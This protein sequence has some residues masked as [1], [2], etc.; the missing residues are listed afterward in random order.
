MLPNKPT[1]GTQLNRGHP[2]TRGLVCALPLNEPGNQ[3]HNLVCGD[4]FTGTH[5]PGG[6]ATTI[7]ASHADWMNLQTRYTFCIWHGGI[8]FGNWD[9]ILY[10]HDG[11]SGYKWQRYSSNNCIR[12]YHSGGNATMW[13]LL[14]SEVSEPGM[15]AARW[16][17][18]ECVAFVDGQQA[19][20]VAMSWTPGTSAANLTFGLAAY[21]AHLILIY[22]RALPLHEIRALY[23]DPTSVFAPAA[24]GATI[25]LSDGVTHNLAGSITATSGISG[26]AKTTRAVCGSVHAVTSLTALPNRM[27]GLS[28]ASVATTGLLASLSSSGSVTLSGM[29]NAA[30]SLTASLQI[31]SPAPTPL[32]WQKEALFNGMTPAAFRLGTVLTQGWF[33]MRRSGCSAVYRGPTIDQVDDTSPVAVANIDAET[34]PLPAYLAHDPGSRC[35]YVVQRFNGCG[36]RERTLTAAVVVRTGLDGQLAEPV[37]NDVFELKATTFAGNRLHLSWFYCPL[38]QA[39][40]PRQFSVYWDSGTGQVDLDTPLAE[41]P[42]EGRRFYTYKTNPLDDGTYTFLVSANSTQQTQSLPGPTVCCSIRQRI[43]EAVRVL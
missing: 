2:L 16:N 28:A 31:A 10:C 29:L 22:D 26:T 18:V 35:C 38:D 32:P 7:S 6:L 4:I 17:G 42:Y 36:Y 39:V 14:T 25:A 15:F 1:P 33:W 27:R 9:A 19:G 8:T 37:P 11:T 12:I 5:A 3:T 34:I 24:C 30:T 13:D 21:T 20:S 40:P 23:Q 43:P 41:V